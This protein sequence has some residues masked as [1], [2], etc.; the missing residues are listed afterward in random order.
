MKC[1][2]LLICICLY[3]LKIASLPVSPVIASQT[4]YSRTFE[5]KLGLGAAKAPCL[6]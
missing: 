2:V 5:Q 1:L 4:E 3:D 6:N